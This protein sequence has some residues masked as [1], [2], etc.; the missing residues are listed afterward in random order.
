ML[1]LKTQ[2]S[3]CEFTVSSWGVEMRNA[4]VLMEQAET[5]IFRISAVLS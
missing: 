2:K 1:E 5:E 3:F 4:G